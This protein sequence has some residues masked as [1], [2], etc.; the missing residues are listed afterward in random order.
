MDTVLLLVRLFLAGV[1]SVAAVA[2]LADLSG[3]KEAM[4]N[5]GLPERLASPAGIALPLAE[6]AVAALLLPQATA[7]WGALGALA[8]LLAF[9][10]GIGVNLAQGRTPDCHCFGQLHSAPAGLPTVARNS[11][12][13]AL[14]GFVL[15]QG[16]DDPGLSMIA[17]ADDLSTGETVALGVGLLALVLVAMVGWLTIQLLQ[18]NGRL[19]TRIEALEATRE[20]G[21]QIAGRAAK[22]GLEASDA[23]LPVGTT[24]GL[25]VG[26]TAPAFSLSALEGETVTLDRLRAG[27]KPVVLVFT[28]PGCGPC[29]ALM[30]EI[31]RWQQNHGQSLTLAL[32][33]RGTREANAAEVRE[34]GISRVLLQ[35]D[36]EVAQAYQS[37][38]TPSAVLIHPDGTIG[39]PTALGSEAIRSLIRTEM[40][41]LPTTR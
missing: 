10:A 32:V 21:G 37:I 28:D 39:A 25:P 31:G 13:A 34:H 14:A 7:W 26:T 35:Q 36:R 17:W 4:R 33:S 11:G 3:S 20:A 8:L 29:H 30:P 22:A 1:F 38:A 41:P 6:L 12:L 5:F 16:W 23:G 19:L 9:I 2:K 24:A 27:G 18:Q 15:W 40:V